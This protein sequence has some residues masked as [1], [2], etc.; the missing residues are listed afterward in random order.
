MRQQLHQYI[1]IADDKNI[2]ALYTLLQNDMEPEHSFTAEEMNMLHER[3]EKYLKGE[4]KIYIVRESHDG[5]RAQG[6]LR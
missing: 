3:A 6:K 1:D 2:R 5:I 4:I